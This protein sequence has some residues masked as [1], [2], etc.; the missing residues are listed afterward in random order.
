MKQYRFTMDETIP[1]DDS[2]FIVSDAKEYWWPLDIIM[3]MVMVYGISYT[4]LLLKFDSKRISWLK[5]MK[6]VE[7]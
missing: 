5:W 2:N 7:E 6:M 4:L 1:E 3:Y